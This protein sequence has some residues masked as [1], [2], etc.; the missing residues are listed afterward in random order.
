MQLSTFGRLL[1]GQRDALLNAVLSLVK[2]DDPV[3]VATL[4]KT[5]HNNVLLNG[6]DSDRVHGMVFEISDDELVKVDGYEAPFA[7]ARVLASVASG[8][9][10]WVYVH[11]P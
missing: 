8:A 5:H 2:I 10:V 7:Y 11:A 3:L 9:E 4:G 6:H 1:H